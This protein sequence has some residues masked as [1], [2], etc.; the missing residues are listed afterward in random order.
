[1]HYLYNRPS[2]LSLD[3]H[4]LYFRKARDTKLQVP[5]V[6][7][8]PTSQVPQAQPGPDGTEQVH[9]GPRTP[10][11]GGELGGAHPGLLAVVR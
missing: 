5:G 9:H 6:S 10:E 3:P 4:V 2:S 8:R 1:M 7:S 11:Q